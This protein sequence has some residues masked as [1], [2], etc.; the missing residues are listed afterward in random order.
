MHFRHRKG[1][2]VLH[3]SSPSIKVARCKFRT[4]VGVPL[5]DSATLS[6]VHEQVCVVTNECLSSV[7]YIRMSSATQKID[8]VQPRVSINEIYGIR[9]TLRALGEGT[10]QIGINAALTKVFVFGRI[11]RFGRMPLAAFD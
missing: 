1:L 4:I 11:G 8:S 5:I 7:Q 2:P 6:S 9:K 3:L 10:G